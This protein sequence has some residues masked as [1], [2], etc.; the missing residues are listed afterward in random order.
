MIKWPTWFSSNGK[1]KLDHPVEYRFSIGKERFY[2]FKDIS[3]IKCQRAL[4]VSDF[5]NELAMRTTRDFLLLHTEAIDKELNRDSISIDQ[6]ISLKTLNQQLKERLEMIYETDIIYK[7]A[8]V[9][10]FTLDEN[11]YEYDDQLGRERIALFKSQG[12]AFFFGTLFK[13][14]IGL[15]DI[16]EADLK[17]YMKVGETITKEH[18]KT[19]STILYR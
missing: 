9:V 13:N 5:Y 18:F 16:S 2:Q 19:I 11:V 15:K 8:S 12:D 14:L 10:F 7:I 1:P 4:T 3:K 17:T 6:I